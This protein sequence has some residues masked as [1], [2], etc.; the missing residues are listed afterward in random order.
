MKRF[1]LISE[2]LRTFRR[3]LLTGVLGLFGL[4][5]GI[6]VAL[7]IGLWSLNEFSFD[8]FHKDSERIYRI[9]R[10]GFLNN[11]TV[12]LGSDFGPVAIEVKNEL[13]DVEEYTRITPF[14]RE[15]VKANEITSYERDVIAGDKNLFQFFS[16]KLESG[17]AET[18]LDAPDKIV[19]DRYIADKYFQD[20]EPVGQ[21]FQIFGQQFQISAVME[22]LPE[23]SHLRF[24]IIVPVEGLSWISDKTWE[25]NDNVL[26]YLKLK[27]GSDIEALA[28]KISQITYK[29]FPIYEQYQVTHFL[30]P[31]TDIHFSVG[32]RFDSVVTNDQRMVYIFI[33]IAILILSIACFNF[34]NLFISTSFKRA[35]AIGIK[36]INGISGIRLFLSSFAETALYI[37]VATIIAFIIAVF[38]LPFF[39][40]LT[41]GNLTVDF[42]D[43][44]LYMFVGV[45]MMIT[46]L[47]AGI[48]PVLY[49]LRFNPQEIIKSKLKGGGITLVQRVLVVSQFAASII[50]IA[51]TVIIKKQIHYIQNK[52]LGFSKEQIIWFQPRNIAE[53]Y[54]TFRQEVM[55]NPNI[56]DITTKTCLPNDWN[57]GNPIV[58]DNNPDAQILAEVCHVGFNYIEMMNIPLIEGSIPFNEITSNPDQCLINERTAKALELDDPIGKQITLIDNSKVT[59][60]GVLKDVNTKS[61]HIQVDPQLYVQLGKDDLRAWHF[62]FLKVSS[63]PDEV[64][65]L[66][67]ENWQKYNPDIPF[68]YAFLDNTYNELYHAEATAS[69]IVSAGMGIALLLAF[70]GLFAM[71]HYSTEKRIKEIGVR[72]VNGATIVEIL[73][74]LNKDF[75]KWVVLAIVIASPIALYAMYKWLANFAYKTDLSWWVFVLAGLTSIMIA[76]ATVSWQSWRAATRNPVEALRYE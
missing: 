52:E 36:K 18:C 76:L 20:K 9:C 13:P 64:I 58:T 46:I 30:Q 50:L 5:V 25:N 44:R 54:E 31:L 3:N 23:N 39:N 32:F 42:G 60:T 72:K 49:I 34:I 21:M 27:E 14:L 67:S 70:M 35:K 22:N 40:N 57:N 53:S 43:Y 45:L 29:H 68:E 6:A 48:F 16:F 65:K 73:I 74:L 62:V 56:K 2:I 33:S 17:N 8:K 55:R 24:H 61:L 71:A 4:S 47:A 15:L 26:A 28:S 1:F 51:S 11:E 63:N 19:V 69:K 59:I 37:L 41:G 12:I 66:M 7:I 10:K 38:A 75:V